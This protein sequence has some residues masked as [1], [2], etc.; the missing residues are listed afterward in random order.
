MANILTSRNLSMKTRTRLSHCYVWSTLLYGA[1]TWTIS[2]KM[3][4]KLA[5]FEMWTLRRMLKIT[6]KDRISNNVVLRR[7]GS[8]R[9]L[10]AIV[11]K[12]K[13]AFFGHIIRNGAF[14]RLLL[15]GQ[16]EGRRVVG[17]PCNTWTGDVTRWCRRKYRDC[18]RL[19]QHRGRWRSMT[20]ELLRAEDTDR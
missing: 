17:R 12:K 15:D 7:A 18:V 3:L 20:A 11:K 4:K 19:A 8:A 14:Q 1:E 6:W 16:L 2:D 9:E 10:T 13:L 5:A